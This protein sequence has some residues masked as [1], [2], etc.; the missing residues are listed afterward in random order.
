M[1]FVAAETTSSLQ[2]RGFYQMP[3]DSVRKEPRE[4]WLTYDTPHHFCSAYD[5]MHAPWGNTHESAWINVRDNDFISGMFIWTG[6]DYLGEP[7]P[8]WWPSRSSYFGIVDLAGFPKDVYYLYQSEW[9][10]TP[11]LHLF[12]HWNW[13]EG[14]TVDVWAYYNGADSVA[15]FLNEKSVGFSSKT[16]DRLHAFWRVAYEPGTLTAVSY[17]DGKEYLRRSVKT[18]GEPNGLELSAD[19]DVFIADGSD[20]S[21]VT[22][23][24]IDRDGNPVPDADNM[25]HFSVEGP[26]AIVAV[27]NGSQV[28]HEPFRAN[29]R[30]AFHGKCLVVIR[31][32]SDPGKVTLTAS[33]ESF[34]EDF[35]L[36]LETR[37]VQ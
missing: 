20:L 10:D 16:E 24:V 18:A 13:S 11:V 12:P 23:R 34:A 31:A 17:K 25:I 6:F 1:P 22:V 33:S 2:T 3:S 14:E 36:S 8:Y 28:S 19:R 35:T 27:D 4:W 9:T 37:L 26:A 29:Y 32:G 30:K 7:T 5:N 15:L 21:F